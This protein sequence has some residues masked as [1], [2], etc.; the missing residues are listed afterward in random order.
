[1]NGGSVCAAEASGI[2]NLHRRVPA[3][4]GLGISLVLGAIAVRVLSP[5]AWTVAGAMSLRGSHRFA[6]FA[7][8]GSSASSP[9]FK[10]HVQTA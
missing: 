5:A 6:A 8:T 2:E 3:F 1:V 10:P 9:S 7:N 4:A